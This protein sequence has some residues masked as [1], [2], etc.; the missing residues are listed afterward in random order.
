M[1]HGRERAV[2]APERA[3]RGPLPRRI[4]HERTA[5]FLSFTT[6]NAEQS[7]AVSRIAESRNQYMAVPGFAGTGESY[8]TKAG[9]ELLERHRDRVAM[10]APYGSKKKARATQ[11]FAAPTPHAF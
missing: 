3:S 6:L 11:G 1:A 8:M 9:K 5:A 2:A 7:R 4:S 10:L